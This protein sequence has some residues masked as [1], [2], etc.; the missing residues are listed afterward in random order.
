MA[1]ALHELFPFIP[2]QLYD[3]QHFYCTRFTDEG[4]SRGVA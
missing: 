2:S 4:L 3:G 1:R